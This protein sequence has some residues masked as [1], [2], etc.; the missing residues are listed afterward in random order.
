MHGLCDFTQLFYVVGGLRLSRVVAIVTIETDLMWNWIYQWWKEGRSE[1]DARGAHMTFAKTSMGNRIQRTGIILRRQLWLWPILAV[2]LLSLIGYLITRSIRLT[3]ESN[4]QSQLTT[5]L[6]VEKAMVLKWLS[7]QETSAKT[8]ANN[9]SFREHVEKLV[10]VQIG[11]GQVGNGQVGNGQV[12]GVEPAGQVVQLQEEISQIVAP[13]L[14]NYEFAGYMITD[15]K[16]QV[17]ASNHAM[18]LGQK[19][20][21]WEDD[22]G[23]VFDNRNVV[24]APFASIVPL[25]DKLGQMQSGVPTMFV[26]V[27]V[28]NGDLQVIAALSLRIRPER[29]FT[30]LV[31]LGRIGRSGETYAVDR[32]GVMV[33]NSRFDDALILLGILQDREGTESILQV[34]LRDPGGD[35]TRGYRPKLRR[36]E[37]GFTKAAA[38]LMEKKDGIDITGYRDYRGVPVVGVWTWL[39]NYDFGL[40]TEIDYDEAFEPL[41]ILRRAFYTMFGLLSLSAL[42]IFIFTLIV[43]RLQKE[44]RQAA[45]EAKQLGQYRLEEKLGEGAMGTVYRGH[46]SMLRRQSAIKLLN[47]ERVNETSISRF[48]QE[49]QITCNLNNPHTIAIYDYGRTPEGVFYYAME[50]LD[51]INLQDLVDRFGPLS[52]GRVAKILD[53]LCSSLFEAHSMGLVHRDIKP[54]NVMLNR[55]G[56]V[57]DFVK[58]LDFGLVRAVDEAKRGKGSEGMAGT[59]LYMSPE[60]IQTPDLVDARSDL[61]AVGAVGYFLLTGAPVF[62]ASSFG[63]LCQQHVDAIPVSPSVRSGRS[64]SEDLEYA[65]MACLEKNRAKRPQTARDLSNLLHRIAAS[66]QWTI[67]DADAWWSRY[68]RGVGVTNATTQSSSGQTSNAQSTSRSAIGQ[69]AS[70]RDTMSGET[71][72][73]PVEGGIS[74]KQRFDQTMD[75]GGSFTTRVEGDFGS[76]EN[77]GNSPKT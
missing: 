63:D 10:S 68:E 21:E 36:G 60:S 59:P 41:N 49:V 69:S 13:T 57:P 28:Y 2:F 16:H 15:A 67:Q 20:E 74:D 39:E 65:I 25:S 7:Q 66:D 5:L 55:R 34:Q 14:A 75:Y 40:I 64:V 62:L 50:Y 12:A 19:V 48:E 73:L 77:K 23:K 32:D 1:R 70:S 4:L 46:H 61:Y 33:S 30:R 45:V 37:L 52:D 3:M 11:R 54:A 31:Q 71:K 27:P 44:A 53:Q 29:E 24:T 72:I 26:S 9:S 22:L 17:I 38:A 18:L 43:T 6:D 56:G 8:L 76:G 51:G 58:L 47:V 35:M 42:A